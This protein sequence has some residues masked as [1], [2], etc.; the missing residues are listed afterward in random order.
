MNFSEHNLLISYSYTHKNPVLIDVGAHHGCVSKAFADKG[1]R[2]IAFEPEKKNRNAFMNNLAS[3]NNVTCIGKA[4][5]D[6]SGQKVPFYVSNEHYGIHSLKPFHDTHRL[7]YEVE[8]VRLDDVLLE[9]KVSEVTIL[10]ID[11]EGADFL[12]LKGFN[13]EKYHPELV[14]VEFMD[15]RSLPHFGYCHHDVVNYMKCQGYA[16]FVSEWEQIKEY[17]REGI[18]TEPHTW[19]QC[20]PYPLNHRPAWGNLIF[21]PNHDIDKF[22]VTLD[23]YLS[24]LKRTERIKN[25]IRKIPYAK[26]FYKLLRSFLNYLRFKKDS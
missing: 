1:W 25:R 2:V 3:L 6:V 14:M 22:N 13:F 16:A 20:V 8:T 26:M 7:A 10:K 4:V 17:G 12:A 15:K 19:I 21:V 24:R 23:H 11:I 5:T 9:L 18:A